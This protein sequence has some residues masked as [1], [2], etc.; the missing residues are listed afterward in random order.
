MN[1]NNFL[2]RPGRRFSLKDVDPSYTGKHTDHEAAKQKLGDDIQ[3]LAR[4][5]DKLYADDRWGLLLIFQAM[6]AAG[7]D[8]TIKHV[9]SGIN[10]AGCEVYSFKAPSSGELNHDYLWRTSRTLPQRGK[11]GIF[12]RSYY[13]EVLTVR[14]HPEFLEHSRMPQDLLSKKI[15]KQ[16]YKDIN[17]FEKYLTHNGYQILKFFLYI[18][19]GEQKKRFLAR[20]E[21]TAKNWKISKSDLTERALWDDYMDTF[22]KML[23]ATSTKH[24]PWYIIPANHKW[25]AHLAVADILVRTLDTLDLKYPKLTGEQKKLLVEMKRSLMREKD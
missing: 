4:L 8:S 11:I 9:M 15:W 3:R 22:E 18:S 23:S 6:D 12:N 24:A 10:P 16:R 5:Q 19:K 1:L 13:E 7:K 21:D 25:F 2:V 14:V 20:V 17:S